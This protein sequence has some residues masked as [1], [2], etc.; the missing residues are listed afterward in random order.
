MIAILDTGIPLVNGSLYHDDLDDPSRFFLGD[1]IVGDGNGVKD[2]NGHGSHVTGIAAAESDNDE[3]IAGVCWDCSI[4]A[5]QVLDE[6]KNGTDDEF[7]E[8]VMYAEEEGGVHIINA[9]LGWSSP[10]TKIEDAVQHANDNDIIVVAAA[11]NE[12]TSGGAIIWPARYSTSYSNVIA[13]GA[14]YQNDSRAS[15]SSYG[16]A[17]NIVAP[18][19]EGG[20]PNANDI[21][22]TIPGNTYAYKY[23][24]S[25][26]APHVSGLAGL[27]LSLHPSLAPHEVRE[28]IEVTA[29]DKGSS[30]WDQYYGHGRINAY[31][32][33]SALIVP[34]EYSTVNA[35]VNAAGSGDMIVVVGSS[36]LT[37]D[38]ALP[39]GVKLVLGSNANLTLNG[40]YIKSTGGTITRYTG[41]TV[42]PDISVKEDSMLKGLY[43]TIQS[44]VNNASSGQI[45][46][47]YSDY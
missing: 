23:G 17:L 39:S 6:N 35:A 15:Y 22:S 40:Y 44:A 18:G 20:T 11:G 30:G 13:V 36:T 45:V 41:A 31:T 8:G 27:I 4:L 33:V 19:G 42:T 5:V 9:S 34:N 7:L 46:A 43:S 21:Y 25:M 24:T 10:T 2:E 38:I 12:G 14:T 37:G 3:G 26:A 1:D 16:S 28:I 47:I 32:A 29:D